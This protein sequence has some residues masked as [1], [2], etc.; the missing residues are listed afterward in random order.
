MANTTP[1]QN[2]DGSISYL[3]RVYVGEKPDGSQDFKSMTYK[4]PAG[5]SQKWI[6]DELKKAAWRFEEKIKQSCGE[7]D[8]TIRF[9]EYAQKWLDAADL[10]PK[11]RERYID[12]LKRINEAIGHKKLCD[13]K[14]LDLKDFYKN[15]AEK[16][17]NNRGKYAIASD[18]VKVMDKSKI[19][20]EKLAKL[21]GV[22]SS[23][24]STAK[25][26]ERVSVATADK[27]AVAL[28]VP[29]N[30]IF[31][32]CN[33]GQGLADKTIFHHYSLIHA[34]L[35]QAED[36]DIITVNV[37]RKGKKSRPKCKKKE[38]RYLTDIEAQHIVQLLLDEQDIRKKTVLLLLLYSGVRRGELCGLSWSDIDDKNK[39][40]HVLRQSQYQRGAGIVEVT[41]KN[42]SSKRPIDMPPFVFRVLSEYK[43]WWLEQ[44]LRNG[45]NWKGA[46]DRLFIQIDGKPIYPDTINYWFNKF[47]EKHGLEHFTPH[48]LRHTFCT[49]QI[50]GG[51]DLRTLQARSGHA[52]ASTLLNTY[53]HAVKTSQIKASETYD[54]VLRPKNRSSSRFDNGA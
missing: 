39:I 25:K 44:Q 50:T 17:I 27:I 18:F 40:I 20:G 48:S 1:R 4:P 54:D 52:Q 8:G 7:Y 30:K 14:S 9:Q 16:G 3:I 38:A 37:A 5:K 32:L 28:G 12:L 41:T 33:E 6:D 21:A 43:K 15:L 10:A 53:S 2:K 35:A 11:T 29:T 22:A 45:T 23:T 26:S 51:V 24:I 19:S 47:I 36:D 13:I 46:E 31:T 42:E 49:L 34:I